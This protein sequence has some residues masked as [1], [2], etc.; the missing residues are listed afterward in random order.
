MLGDHSTFSCDPSG[1]RKGSAR[2]AGT[3]Q[4][5]CHVCLNTGSQEGGF[6]GVAALVY[7][8]EQKAQLRCSSEQAQVTSG[9]AAWPSF[10][11]QLPSPHR[12]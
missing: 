3:G 2:L 12:Q 8:S 9:P 10:W 6:P 1:P 4:E 11:Q 5:D 7:L